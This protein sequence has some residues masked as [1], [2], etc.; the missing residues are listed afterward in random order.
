MQNSTLEKFIKRISQPLYDNGAV[1]IVCLGDSVTQ[2]AF[3]PGE[4]KPEQGY[5]TKF[6]GMLHFLFPNQVFNV[7]NS[8]IG[9]TT[10][11]FATGRFERDV[12]KFNPDLVLVMFGVNDFFDAELYRESLRKIFKELTEREIPCIY[13]TEHMMNTYVKPD[14]EESL[15]DYAEQTSGV[16]NNGTMDAI[17]EDGKKIAAGFSVPVCDMYSKWKSLNSCGVDTTA[18]LANGINHPLPE[19]HTALAYEIISTI[20]YNKQ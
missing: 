6:A 5:V 14:T 2:G 10:A 15:K 11:A 7:I 8:G 20:F 19:M 3:G 1:N 9:G 13:I 12:L 18:L 16:Q 17:F 4:I